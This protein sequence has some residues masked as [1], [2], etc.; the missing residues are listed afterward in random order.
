MQ[1]GGKP[2]HSKGDFI[3]ATFRGDPQ[4]SIICGC[5]RLEHAGELDDFDMLGAVGPIVPPANNYVAA[6][7]RMAVVTEIFALK[8]K[9]DL[10]PLPAARSNLPLG[11][12]VRKALLNGF[13]QEAQIVREHS[14]QQHHALFVHRLMPELREVGGIAVSG[15]V[16]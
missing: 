10:H 8:F 14:K 4:G 3:G 15:A 6:V 2:S 13:D 9:F 16:F 12:A 11:F 5:Q 7:H 1:S